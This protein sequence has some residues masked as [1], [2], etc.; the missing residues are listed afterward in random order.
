L[1]GN[2][3]RAILVVVGGAIVLVV[4]ALAGCGSSSHK[5]S[6]PVSL[7]GIPQKGIDLGNPNA[8]VT[9]I[10][11]T[12]PQCPYCGEYARDTFP[13]LVDKYVR[14]GKVRFEY[15]GVAFIGP[16]SESLLRLAY[17]ASF[18]NKLWDVIELEFARQGTEN[19]GYATDAFLKSIANSVPGLNAKKALSTANT[20]A[21][22]PLI[23][24]S[25]ALAQKDLGE[26]L[27]TPSFIIERKG[28]KAEAI[29]GAQPLSTFTSAIDSALKK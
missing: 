1:R 3:W 2:R 20:N 29:V 5:K 10:E 17:A 16:D 25:Q 8:K 22:V 19:S 28:A 15:A 21:V 26:N 23:N 6:G 4:G 7:S 18:Q 24:A 14:T 13:S 9:M 12:D 27:S 11:V